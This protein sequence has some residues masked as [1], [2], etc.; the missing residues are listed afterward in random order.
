MNYTFD[1][2]KTEY[3]KIIKKRSFYFFFIVQ[4]TKCNFCKKCKCCKLATL[5]LSIQNCLNF[6]DFNKKTFNE[7][8]DIFKAY[9]ISV[10][11]SLKFIIDTYNENDIDKFTLEYLNNLFQD[12]SQPLVKL[13]TLILKE[14][15]TKFTMA[16]SIIYNLFYKLYVKILK[17]ISY[18]QSLIVINDIK[19]NNPSNILTND[20][21]NDIIGCI[22]IYAI[23][24]IINNPDYYIDFL[25]SLI[26]NNIL[27]DVNI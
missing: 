14:Y 6:K 22:E 1:K 25:T 20:I 3:S 15:Q 27:L 12:I 2:I 17:S 18:L 21:I 23:Y 16:N 26:Y 8:I 4:L 7:Q 11:A 10:N 13:T 24:D 19:N 5:I 9:Y